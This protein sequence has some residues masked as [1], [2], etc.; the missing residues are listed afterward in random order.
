MKTMK[1]SA[2][3]WPVSF[4]GL[5]L[6]GLA[7][8]FLVG[9]CHHPSAQELA[10]QKAIARH[11]RE[12]RQRKAIVD[13]L[14][15]GGMAHIYGGGEFLD[16]LQK[17]GQLP[18]LAKGKPVNGNLEKKPEISPNGRYFFTEQ[19]RLHTKDSPPT[20]YHYI[21][22]QTYSNSDFQLLAAWHTDKAGEKLETYPVHPA[23]AYAD[24]FLVRMGLEIGGAIILAMIAGVV[25]LAWRDRKRRPA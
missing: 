4:R 5:W 14:R 6:L 9:G 24:R 18:G 13:L 15:Q 7:M 1:S 20:Y 11:E 21:V 12:A 19:F 3:F 16:H 17:A 22:V 2:C 10:E 8:S 25:W 23:P